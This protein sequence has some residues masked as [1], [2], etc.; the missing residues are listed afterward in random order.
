MWLFPMSSARTVTCPCLYLIALKTVV[1]PPFLSTG[2]QFVRL[3]DLDLIIPNDGLSSV[4][5]V[6]I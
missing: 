5:Y 1:K 4:S 6:S 3:Y 2:T